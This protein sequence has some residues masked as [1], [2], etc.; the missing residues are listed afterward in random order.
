VLAGLFECRVQVMVVNA[1]VRRYRRLRP[2]TARIA[3]GVQAG[4]VMIW[5]AWHAVA[6]IGS[7]QWIG[8]KA[9][10]KRT[11]R[12]A[13]CSRGM[14][15]HADHARRS[16]RELL[17]RQCLRPVDRPG[18]VYLPGDRVKSQVMTG[19]GAPAGKNS[20]NDPLKT[21]AGSRLKDLDHRS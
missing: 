6:V 21:L 15:R 14:T 9:Q 17:P 19:V 3:A 1:A 10:P 18:W 20:S 16:F 2:S 5:G 12:Q 8:V 11:G 13:G 7:F 4:R